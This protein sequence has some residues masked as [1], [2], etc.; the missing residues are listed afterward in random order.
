MDELQRY[1][2]RRRR[3]LMF[4]ITIRDPGEPARWA[5]LQ[6]KVEFPLHAVVVVNGRTYESGLSDLWDPYLGLEVDGSLDAR[7]ARQVDFTSLA[8]LV[9]S[10]LA[11]FVDRMTVAGWT[12]PRGHVDR[13]N[14]VYWFR[15]ERPPDDTPATLAAIARDAA[16]ALLGTDQYLLTIEPFQGVSRNVIGESAGY[17]SLTTMGG[18]VLSAPIVAVLVPLLTHNPLDV[19]LVVGAL[20]AVAA[21]YLLLQPGRDPARSR[22]TL[23][24][25]LV[26]L[27]L[28][29]AMHESAIVD[30]PIVGPLVELVLSLAVVLVGVWIPIV[31][32]IVIT[33]AV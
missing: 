28:E 25:D 16:A 32:A 18:F 11:D 10:G 4:A 7:L 20:V 13:G 3:R 31:V 8:D 27:K 19:A 22:P 29:M 2:A 15:R 30:L 24:L 9:A 23:E 17:R 33:S 26:L 12:E 5:R 21:L 6:F 1:L 14:Q